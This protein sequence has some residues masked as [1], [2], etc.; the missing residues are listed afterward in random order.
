[1]FSRPVQRAHM[2]SFLNLGELYILL[3]HGRRELQIHV[4]GIG[5]THAVQKN[6]LSNILS[7]V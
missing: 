2:M 4:G 7:D 1:M 5:D 3:F 6:Y